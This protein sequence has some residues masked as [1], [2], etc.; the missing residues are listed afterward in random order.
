MACGSPLG[1]AF[2]SGRLWF[3]LWRASEATFLEAC[4]RSV[5]FLVGAVAHDGFFFRPRFGQFPA[6]ARQ[7]TEARP[8][9]KPTL[10]RIT[11]TKLTWCIPS[12]QAIVNDMDDTAQ[13]RMVV[14]P[15]GAALLRE[16]VLDAFQV[17]VAEPE[18][19][20]HEPPFCRP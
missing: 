13:D 6:D 12:S 4:R 8:S 3:D 16:Q 9:D 1:K 19:M 18:E 5:C 20:R 14:S 11:R 17:L 10:E 7:E 2:R 15:S